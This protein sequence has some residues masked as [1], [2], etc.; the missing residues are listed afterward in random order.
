MPWQQWVGGEDRFADTPVVEHAR[1]IAHLWLWIAGTAAANIHGHF[2]NWTLHQSFNCKWKVAECR[3]CINMYIRYLEMCQSHVVWSLL[4]HWH[5]NLL[6][7]PAAAWNWIEIP[8]RSCALMLVNIA[9]QLML[10]NRPTL[11]LVLK[12]LKFPLQSDVSLFFIY[13]VTEMQLCLVA[14]RGSGQP[15]EKPSL[16]LWVLEMLTLDA[17]I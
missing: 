12:L 14:C 9:K 5:F 13:I 2:R 6:S 4:V 10:A 3:I 7:C 15:C 17:E 11:D 1:T 8:P 16:R